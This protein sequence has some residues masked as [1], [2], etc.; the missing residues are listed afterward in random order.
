MRRTARNMRRM[1]RG[2]KGKAKIEPARNFRSI[3]DTPLRRYR[4]HLFSDACFD[5]SF[6]AFS[7][8]LF[9]SFF[10]WRFDQMS[11]MSTSVP[12]PDNWTDEQRRL[13]LK[14]GKRRKSEYC[15]S[16]CVISIGA[17]LYYQT[18]IAREEAEQ[19]AEETNTSP[20]N[21]EDDEI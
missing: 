1:Y 4:V 20:H 13:Y 7:L 3:W 16:Y 10:R 6:G 15:L 21:E 2:R 8:S 11:S 12:V 18:T 17:L 9:L 14:I 5:H 19:A